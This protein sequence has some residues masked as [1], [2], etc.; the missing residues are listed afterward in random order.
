[1]FGGPL[2]GERR[3]VPSTLSA[4]TVAQYAAPAN[5][6]DQS[7]GDVPLVK[8]RYVRSRTWYGRFTYDGTVE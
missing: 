7:E 5:P 3:V 4:I 8:H 6:W 1:M 2:D